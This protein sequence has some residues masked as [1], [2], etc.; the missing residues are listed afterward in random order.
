VFGRTLNPRNRTLTSGGSSGGE[1]ALL[2][3]KGSI[4]GVG[5]DY[6]MSRSRVFRKTRCS[7]F[8]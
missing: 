4:L 1:A 3:L 7:P 6:G 8:P 5:T 2:A